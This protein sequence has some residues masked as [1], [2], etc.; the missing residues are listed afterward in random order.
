MITIPRNQV[1]KK[2]R[3]ILPREHAVK[4]IENRH[5]LMMYANGQQSAITRKRLDAA[6]NGDKGLIAKMIGIFEQLASTF[7]MFD[8]RVSS[9]KTVSG[10]KS[11]LE[12]LTDGESHLKIYPDV[13]F[14]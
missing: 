12:Y 9:V 2:T 13:S 5:Y 14:N 6:Y 4:F 1:V 11:L 7:A 10:K 3:N 8:E